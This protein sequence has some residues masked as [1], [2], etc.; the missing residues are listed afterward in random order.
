MS[1]VE[2]IHEK[3]KAARPEL[4]QEVLDFVEFLEA[5]ARKP[6]SSPALSWNDVIGSLKNSKALAGD[7]V[8]I[9]RR[10]RAEWD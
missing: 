4:V 6:I 8:E 3:L 2:T 9:Q 10:L 5:K 1:I 7:P